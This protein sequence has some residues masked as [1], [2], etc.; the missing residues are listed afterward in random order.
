MEYAPNLYSVIRTGT[1]ETIKHIKGP[2]AFISERHYHAE[3][4]SYLSIFLLKEDDQ[5]DGRILE[6]EYQK[7]I[8]NQNTQQRP[9]IIYHIPTELTG[10]PP[11]L[12]NFAVWAFKLRASRTRAEED[13]TKLDE[14]IEKLN[15]YQ[16]FFINIASF[17]TMAE[18]YTRKHSNISFISVNFSNNKGHINVD[19]IIS[20]EI[21]RVSID[22][23]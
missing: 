10:S 21:H 16:G 14:I 7:T 9:D 4:F 23:S 3:F 12:N 18:F 8:T 19:D 15:Y 11:D 22:F 2:R 17:T 13:F 1:I 5:K 6:F 20:N